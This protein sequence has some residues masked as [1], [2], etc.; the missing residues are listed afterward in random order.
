MGPSQ[1]QAV[2]AALED[3]RISGEFPLQLTVGKES[4]ATRNRCDALRD[5]RA[6][7]IFSVEVDAAV[8]IYASGYVEDLRRIFGSALKGERERSGERGAACLPQS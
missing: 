4:E 7:L 3:T 6:R 2:Y 5:V 1:R 8:E